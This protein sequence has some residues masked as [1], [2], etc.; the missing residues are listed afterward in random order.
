M[1]RILCA[2][3][4]ALSV[5]GWA[6]V[7]LAQ[8]VTSPWV[9]SIRPGTKV[10]SLA[11]SEIFVVK[12]SEPLSGVGTEDFTLTPTGGVSAII[13]AGTSNGGGEYLV[14]VGS[15][16]GTGTLRLDLKSSGTDIQDAA[17]N[18]IAGGF[19]SGEVRLVGAPPAA[20]PTLTEW[21]MILLGLMLAGVAALT[22]QRRRTA[23]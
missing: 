18:P 4:G 5:L 8:D 6:S 3:L 21:A 14:R 10:P 12:F 16:S 19:T 17:A 2:L 22:I 7:S 9:V 23:A 15:I 11:T 13:T 1:V 20:V